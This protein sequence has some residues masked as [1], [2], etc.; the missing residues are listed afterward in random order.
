MLY[1][2][3]GR[4]T[5]CDP[6]AVSAIAGVPTHEAAA[7]IRRLYDRRAVNGVYMN[8]LAAALAEFGCATSRAGSTASLSA[9]TSI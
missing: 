3:T 2:I 1:R 7:V 5:K 4:A 9:N 6:S 8:E